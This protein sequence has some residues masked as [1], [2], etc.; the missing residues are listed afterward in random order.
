M[1][2][3][4][5]DCPS[6]P[7]SGSTGREH[8][9]RTLRIPQATDHIRTVRIRRVRRAF[10]LVALSPIFLFGIAFLVDAVP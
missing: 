2:T 8:G 7:G 6:H 1:K 4:D 5:P 3:D 9:L 10:V